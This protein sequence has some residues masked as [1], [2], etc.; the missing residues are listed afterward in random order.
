MYSLPLSIKMRRFYE[1]FPRVRRFRVFRVIR[2][3]KKLTKAFNPSNRIFYIL[4]VPLQFNIEQFNMRP[5][6]TIQNSKFKHQIVAQTGARTC[7]HAFPWWALCCLLSSRTASSLKQKIPNYDLL[8]Y[9]IVTN[10]HGIADVG[11]LCASEGSLVAVPRRICKKY[12]IILQG[13]A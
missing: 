12:T 5:R 7:Y 3:F 1:S 2:S 13:A 10:L 8:L 11:Q 9:F 6:R 4:D